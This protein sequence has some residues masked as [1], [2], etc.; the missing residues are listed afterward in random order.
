MLEYNPRGGDSRIE[1]SWRI[2]S[3]LSKNDNRTNLVDLRLVCGLA[4]I[5]HCHYS[6]VKDGL[7]FE[8]C[9]FLFSPPFLL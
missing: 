4:L 2:V 6:M 3:K 5:H 9:S 8:N 7:L 1:T